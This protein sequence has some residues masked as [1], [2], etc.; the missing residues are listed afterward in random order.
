MPEIEEGIIEIKAAARDPGARAKIAVASHDQRVDPI[1]TCIGMR[2]SRVN[3]VTTE[4]GERIDIVV[5][6]ADP[7]QFVVGAL[8]PPRFVRS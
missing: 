3:A 8:S 6:N 4:L 1:G 5:W 7:A 2:G